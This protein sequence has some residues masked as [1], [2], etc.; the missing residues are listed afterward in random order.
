MRPKHKKN[1]FGFTIVELLI[2]IVIIGILAAITIVSYNGIQDRA[3]DV[4]IRDAARKLSDAFALWS[5]D[6]PGVD[7]R[8]GGTSS[9]GPATATGCHSSSAG[10]NQDW[11]ASSYPGYGCTWGDILVASKYLPANFF[12]SLPPN[13]QNIWSNSTLLNF[14]TYWCGSDFYLLYPLKKPTAADVASMSMFRSGGACN[15]HNWLYT[16]AGMRAAIKLNVSF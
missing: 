8:S 9:V 11:V 7:P 5:A 4:I 3:R 1:G 2:V 15:W 12:S 10:N 6:N 16:D 14:T 13:T